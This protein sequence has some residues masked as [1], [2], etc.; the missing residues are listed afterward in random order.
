MEVKIT[1]KISSLFRA[2][3]GR[4]LGTAEPEQGNGEEGARSLPE[5][6]SRAAWAARQVKT[7]HGMYVDK[8]KSSGGFFERGSGA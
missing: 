5:G 1:G 6:S 2:G 8:R 4:E 3:T 7:R